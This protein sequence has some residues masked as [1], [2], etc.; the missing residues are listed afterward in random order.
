MIKN[1]IW[2]LFSD[3]SPLNGAIAIGVCAFVMMCVFAIADIGTGLQQKD[4][5][6]IKITGSSSPNI[7]IKNGD[8]GIFESNFPIFAI[9]YIIKI[10]EI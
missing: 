5:V 4:L 3:K 8:L 2:H 1:F 9:P 6:V 10:E 7:P